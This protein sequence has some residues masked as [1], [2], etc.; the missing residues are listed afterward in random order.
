M[1]SCTALIPRPTLP[2]CAPLIAA[3]RSCLRSSGGR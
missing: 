1:Q 3:K 2:R